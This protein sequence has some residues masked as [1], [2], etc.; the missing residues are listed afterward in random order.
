MIAPLTMMLLPY[1]TKTAYIPWEPLTLKE[2]AFYHIAMMPILG[3]S[4]WTRG[5]EKINKILT[6]DTKTDTPE[7]K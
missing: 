5:K 4:A 3:V 6:G 2:S 7:E 1:L